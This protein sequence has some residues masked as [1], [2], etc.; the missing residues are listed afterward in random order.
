MLE[1]DRLI[2]PLRA[3]LAARLDD[4][5]APLPTPV[6]NRS[7][8]ALSVERAP[9]FCSGCPHNVSTRAEPGTLVGGGI[10]CHAMVGLMEPERVGDL[11]GLTCMGNE[12]AQWIGMAPFLERK[13]LVQNL[14]DGT[15]FHSGS[16]AIRATVAA[17]VDITFKLLH[18]GTVAMTGGQDAVGAVG[19]PDIVKMVLLEGVSK[20]IVTTDDLDRY[21]PDEFPEGVDVWHRTRLDEA[22]KVLAAIPGTTVLLHDQA[23][24]AENRRARSRGKL[25]TPDFRVVINERV[26]EGCGDCGAKSNCLSVQ[27][28]DTPYGRKT[29]I[30][31]TICNFDFSCM[32]G[33]CPAFA[34]VSTDPT[35]KQ[36]TGT[37]KGEVDVSDL[38]APT[39]I[40][41]P[42]RFTVRLSGI[43]GTGVVT[44]SQILGTAAMLAGHSVR[45]LDQT[46]LSQKA[47]PVSSDIRIT[48]RPSPASN[49]ASVS[50]V[51]ALL[52]FDLLAAASDSHR[53]GATPD[54]TV[55][56]ANRH[57]VPTG[58]MVADPTIPYPAFDSLRGRLRPGVAERTEPL[59]RHRGD[60]EWP[61]RRH[62]DHQHLHARR[63]NPDR[64][65]TRRHRTL[66]A[67]D[68]A[69]R[70][71][72]RGQYR[73]VPV[74]TPVGRRPGRC[75]GCSRA[76][77]PAGRDA[78][79]DGR[80]FR[81]RPRRLPVAPLRRSLPGRRR[82]GACR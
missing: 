42:S 72:G 13:H 16:L 75:G 4:R 22:Q 70:R 12:G 64:R 69:Q 26:C 7:L 29:R 71:S 37:S 80:P 5:L 66:G 20:V 1:A 18:N 48:D 59:P 3:R 28:V 54:R 11:V 40:V 23:C 47:G 14:G 38:P 50:G 2:A 43:G 33:D 9:F 52:A 44:V 31:Q 65:R 15:F 55:V 36:R 53:K 68:R 62:H 17:G 73:C 74:G 58:G 63:R 79:R 81:R 39:P 10:G 46:G 78:R 45:G 61:V 82:S 35:G 51:D 60:H 76:R 6:G 30:D 49:H 8:I 25:A 34:T 67:G 32:E 24:A 19:V 27:P 57:T 21:D 41:D 56:I 77:G